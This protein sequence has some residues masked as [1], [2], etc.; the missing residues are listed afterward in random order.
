M[1][2]DGKK[3]RLSK[4]SNIYLVTKS[5]MQT[6]SILGRIVKPLLRSLL[7]RRT[8]KRSSDENQVGDDR[9]V[10]RWI[11]FLWCILV[12]DG[13]DQEQASNAA[14]SYSGYIPKEFTSKYL[15]QANT[16]GFLFAFIHWLDCLS[17]FSSVSRS[18]KIARGAAVSWYLSP[19]SQ[20]T[21]T[22]K[23]KLNDFKEV[24]RDHSLVVAVTGQLQHGHLNHNPLAVLRLRIME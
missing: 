12:W 20:N 21:H 14:K 3:D 10:V 16:S 15:I 7:P 22:H 18:L 9:W 6:S 2:E 19:K 17:V 24:H 11:P 8:I 4:D 13:C 1:I 23:Q 5:K